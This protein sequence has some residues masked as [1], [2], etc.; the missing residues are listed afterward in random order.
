VAPFLTFVEQPA[1]EMGRMATE[2]LL[3]R[4]SGELTGG[5]QKLFLPTQIIERGS[6]APNRNSSN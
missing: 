6:T 2:L 4:I 5:Y 1:Y 3:K